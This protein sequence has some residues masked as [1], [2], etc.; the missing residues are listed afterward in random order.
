MATNVGRDGQGG[1][2][3][4]DAR[5]ITLDALYTLTMQMLDHMDW[6]NETLSLLMQALNALAQA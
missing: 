6:K 1:G 5:G 3:G 4:Q 2:V